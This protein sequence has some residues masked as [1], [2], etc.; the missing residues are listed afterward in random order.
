MMNTW[1]RLLLGGAIVVVLVLPATSVLALTHGTGA[2]TLYKASWRGGVAGW[3]STGG[4]W[5]ARTGTL[6]FDGKTQSSILAPYQIKRANYA[7]TARV[8]LVYYRGDGIYVANS[9]GILFRARHPSGKNFAAGL[10]GGIFETKTLYGVTYTAAL[11]TDAAN[12]AQDDAAG[13]YLQ[14]VPSPGWHTYRVEVRGNNAQL[15][16]DGKQLVD[17]TDARF[18]SAT[19]AGIFSS[20]TEIEVGSFAVSSR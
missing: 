10:G 13:N 9:F 5:A 18:A 2:K 8:R 4:T 7:I 11:I 20:R 15:H 12:P 6:S 14:F 1:E 19:L 16:A 3:T 17:V